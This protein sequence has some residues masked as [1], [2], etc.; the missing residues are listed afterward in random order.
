MKPHTNF[1]FLIIGTLVLAI[2]YF[3]A[4][5]KHPEIIQDWMNKVNQIN[6]W[7][8]QDTPETLKDKP[9]EEKEDVDV[10]VDTDAVK[11]IEPKEEKPTDEELLPPKRKVYPRQKNRPHPSLMIEENSVE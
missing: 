2:G 10:D 11:P 6:P 1:M 4:E 9:K 7:N 8:S 5:K 3:Y